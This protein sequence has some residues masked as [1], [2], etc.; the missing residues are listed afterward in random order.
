MASSRRDDSG[1]GSTAPRRLV[2][3]FVMCGVD[4]GGASGV[5]S[6]DVG[7]ETGVGAAAG[8][9]AVGDH[10]KPVGRVVARVPAEDIP[11]SP[12]PNPDQLALVRVWRFAGIAPRTH[13]WLGC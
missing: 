13:A 7:A 8:G 12:L 3:Y 5:T 1:V 2:Q 6:G 4:R 9:G 11:D 10:A